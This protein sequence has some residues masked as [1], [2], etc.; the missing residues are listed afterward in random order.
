MAVTTYPVLVSGPH[1]REKSVQR[2]LS[3]LGLS[4]DG[5]DFSGQVTKRNYKQIQRYCDRNGLT[6]R[7]TNALGRRRADY[8][9]RFFS[10]H[11]P[12]VGSRYICV[13]CGKWLKREKVTVDH[14]Y[15]VG[16]ASRDV[17]L[18]KKLERQGIHNINDPRNLVAS[19]QSCNARKANQMG[20]WI[21]RGKLGRHPGFWFLLYV[22]GIAAIA[23]AGACLYMVL[24]I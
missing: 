24:T 2:R 6:V 23:G 1:L 4:D 3:R 5:I 12:D 21:L 18:Q 14:L 7:L 10:K 16:R 19:C 8:R 17:H 15:P 13:Y 9:R 20:L 22:L 11:E